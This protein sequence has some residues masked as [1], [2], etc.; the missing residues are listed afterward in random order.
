MIKITNIKSKGRISTKVRTVIISW[1]EAKRWKFWS[2]E[3]GAS[4]CNVPALGGLGGKFIALIIL[5]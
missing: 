4:F 1:E 2:I 5:F 3:A